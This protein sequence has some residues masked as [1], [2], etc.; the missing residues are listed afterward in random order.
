MNYELEGEMQGHSQAMFVDARCVEVG[1]TPHVIYS[2][3]RKYIIDSGSNLHVG[4]LAHHGA[5]SILGETK[6]IL[7]VGRIVSLA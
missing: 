2:Q 1:K 6:Q 4:G 5:E 3:H 7:V